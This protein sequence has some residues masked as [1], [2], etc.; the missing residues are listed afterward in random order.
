MA[1]IPGHTKQYVVGKQ[2]ILRIELD[3]SESRIEQLVLRAIKEVQ[4]M[5]K[6]ARMQ[7]AKTP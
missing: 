5:L 1:D 6:D 2:D 3:D 7:T 4:A